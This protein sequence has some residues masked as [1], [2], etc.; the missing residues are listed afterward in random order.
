MKSFLSPAKH[1]PLLPKEKIDSIYKSKRFQVFIGIFIGYAGYYLVR[2]NFS[3]AMPY[4]ENEGFTKA[5]LGFA[6]SANAIAYGLS[7]F[8]MGGV[9]DRSD[10]RKFLALG[11]ILSS[12]VTLVLGTSLGV[13][14][15][16]IMFILQFLIGWFQGMGWPPCGRVMTHWFSQ[17]ERGTKMS[18]WNI[19]HNVGGGLLAPL[20][21]YATLWF[22]SWQVG[23]F[24]VPAI[25]GIAIA[26][27]SLLL[28]RDTP[29][30]CGLPPIEEYRND[31]PKNYSKNSEEELSTK[32]IF[33]TYVLNN[34]TLWFI[35]IANAFVYL[36]RYGVLDWAP[37]YLQ[38][39]KHY[40]IKEVSW[41]YSA[42]E[43]AAIP[44]TILCGWL[45]D[46]IFKGKR[47]LITIIYMALVTVFV[48]IYWKNM[49]NKV[50]DGIALIAIGF[51]IYG[52]VM[53]IGVQALDLAPKKA[54]GTAA[55]LTGLLGY[56]LGT[57]ILA[58]ITMGYLVEYFGWDSGFI[59]LIIACLLSIIFISFTI[60]DE[61]NLN[62]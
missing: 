19:A 45:S 22:G 5:S 57:A 28:V 7:K 3:L 29:Q 18:F 42:Y 33:F 26:L 61:K 43:W 14:S 36:V 58:N 10:A 55:G 9:S 34:R 1:L 30:S 13:S 12:L 40:D 56:L 52:P 17:N 6:L 2:K 44:G 46:K 21:G 50:L 38:A 48:F 49:D 60:K 25:V 4:L 23:T 37:T 31:Y 27:I 59:L 41:A 53:L 11:L 8:F 62:P 39:V 54:A 51:L 35:A 24:W 15:I 47:S 20:V 32:D 16:T